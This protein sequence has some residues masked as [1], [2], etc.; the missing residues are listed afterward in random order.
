[1]KSKT[2]KTV[3]KSKISRKTLERLKKHHPHLYHAL[4][5]PTPKARLRANVVDLRLKK[6]LSRQELAK[7][8]KV[9]FRTL[10]RIEQAHP[11]SNPTVQVVEG[12]ARA[13]GVDIIDLYRL[14]NQAETL[15]R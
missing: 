5:N 12:L 1:M 2:K 13:L 3:R 7:K 15:I 4:K 8:A 11:A 9:G 14:V 6:G 10:Q